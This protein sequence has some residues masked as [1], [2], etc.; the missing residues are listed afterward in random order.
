MN[1]D[2]LASVARIIAAIAPS[3]FLVFAEDYSAGFRVIRAHG[4]E[5]RLYVT[6]DPDTGL[7]DV[8]ICHH[9]NGGP[10]FAQE[11]IK[12]NDLSKVLREGGL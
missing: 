12:I 5:P 4:F 9:D 2:V 8:E 1:I 10:S 3:A 11:G 6:L 7:I